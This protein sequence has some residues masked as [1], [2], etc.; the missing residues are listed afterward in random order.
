MCQADINDLV[1]EVAV[2]PGNSI[3][4]RPLGPRTPEL[5]LSPYK[6][7]LVM[8]PRE[9]SCRMRLIC[10]SRHYA[11]NCVFSPKRSIQ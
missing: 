11:L 1:A 3:E 10:N 2:Q 9:K 8:T 4:M 6:K 5:L 7:E